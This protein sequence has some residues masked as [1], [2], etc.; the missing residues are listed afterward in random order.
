MRSDRMRILYVNH[1]GNVSGA[2]RVLL[3]I[4]Q[5]LDRNRYEPIMLCPNEGRLRREVRASDVECRE[6]P[7]VGARFSLRPDQLI[8]S[9]ASM[10]GAILTLRRQVSEI[11]PDLVHANTIRSGISSTLATV[12]TTTPVLWHVHDILPKHPLSAAIRLLARISNRTHIVAVSHATARAF[13]GA[14]DFGGRARTIHNGVDLEKFP[15]KASGL[16]PFRRK[17]EIPQGSFLVC[18][19]GQIC[20]RKG[21]RELIDAFQRICRSAPQMHLAI[22]GAVVFKHEEPYFNA[23]RE[24]ADKSHCPERIHFTG[25]LSDVSDVLQGADLLVLN[26]RQ[27]PFGLVLVEAMSSG[28]PV[29]ATRVGGI[30]EIVTDRVNGWLIEPG[31]SIGLASKLLVLSA[32]RHALEEVAQ[33]ARRTTCP[34]FAMQRFHNNLA[35]LYSEFDEK[36]TVSYTTPA[37]LAFVEHGRP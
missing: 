30:P 6:L 14:M 35:R 19:V 1:T 5:G 17:L 3:D 21:L 20:E 25:E 32:D 10:C 34:Q 36:E 4:L 11:K 23:L 27:E 13:S 37:R 26:S 31:D 16:S 29:V 12:G 15:V 22:V 7:T 33:V 8:R 9:I 18:A 24:L 28:V 2:E